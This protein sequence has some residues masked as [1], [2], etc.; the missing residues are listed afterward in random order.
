[1]MCDH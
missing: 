1:L